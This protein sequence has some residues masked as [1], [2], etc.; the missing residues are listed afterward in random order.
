[1]RHRPTEAK[2]SLDRGLTTRSCQLSL[3][4]HKIL[5]LEPTQKRYALIMSRL[6]FSI[7]TEAIK[8]A[9]EQMKRP[10]QALKK[11]ER[12]QDV[13]GPPGVYMDLIRY[14]QYKNFFFRG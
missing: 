2:A 12:S 5:K 10:I 3:Y 7:C 13:W 8:R 9:K 1:M 14:P 11:P 6:V 4:T